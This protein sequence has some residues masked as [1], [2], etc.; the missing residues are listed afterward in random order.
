MSKVSIF[1]F[2]FTA[3]NLS[4]DDLVKILNEKAKKWIFQKEKC[5]TTGTEHFQGRCSLKE[6]TKKLWPLGNN[7]KC[8]P[9]HSEDDSQ[10]YCVKEASK[11]EGPWSDRDKQVYIPKQVRDVIELH[12]WQKQVIAD[13]E[14]WNTRKIN[15]ILDPRGGAGKSTLAMYILSHGL[16]RYVPP[17]KDFKDVMRMIMD[18]DKKRLY[19]IDVPRS[20][21]NQKLE[22]EFFAALE[23]IKNGYCYDDRYHFREQVFDSPNLWIFCNT[24]PPLN[25]LSLDRWVVYSIDQNKE[26]KIDPALTGAPL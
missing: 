3:F 24:P 1:R 23:T 14:V 26:L 20:M 5:P 4:K 19:I 10:F 11:I 8:S 17:M 18:T 21:M 6:K 22:T 2:A 13:A 25:S 15:V 12:P 9:E 16:G 7:I